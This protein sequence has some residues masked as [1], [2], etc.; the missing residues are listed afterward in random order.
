M[1]EECPVQKLAH[2]SGQTS[3]DE[4]AGLSLDSKMVADAIKAM[5][6]L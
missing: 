3:Y 1:E 4:A 2:E 6:F 5:K